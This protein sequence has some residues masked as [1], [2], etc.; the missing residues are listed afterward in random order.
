MT[1]A[2]GSKG[3][4]EKELKKKKVILLSPLKSEA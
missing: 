3:D 4:Y 2:L 1:L